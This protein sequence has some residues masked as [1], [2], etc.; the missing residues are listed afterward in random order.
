MSFFFMR[1]DIAYKTGVSG[2]RIGG[3]IA[4][5]DE[6]DGIS[7]KGAAVISLCEAPEFVAGTL[8]PYG[9]SRAFEEF[10]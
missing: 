10:V 7:A 9:L 1:F 2:F 5:G 6:F 8:L 3:K 4:A